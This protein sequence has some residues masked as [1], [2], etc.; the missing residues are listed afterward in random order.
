MQ[1]WLWVVLGLFLIVVVAYIWSLAVRI[2]RLHRRVA[3]SAQAIPLA[4]VRRAASSVQLA[5]SGFLDP[6]DAAKLLD[7]ANAALARV[8]E[9]LSLPPGESLAAG[10]VPRHAIE[11]ELSEVLRDVSE[12]RA[13]EDDELGALIWADLDDVRYRIQV[14]R[15]IHNQDVSLV[16]KLRSRPSARVLRLAGFAR[17]PRYID[18]DDNV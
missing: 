11:S 17:M 14:A 3:Q 8:E 5:T 9:P 15:T 1:T 6:D 2:D 13:G 12:A 18:L 16:Q 7:A 4:L 10:V